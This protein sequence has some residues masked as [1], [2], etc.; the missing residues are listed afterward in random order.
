[1][2]LV[3]YFA[4][5]FT[6]ICISLAYTHQH[7]LL[8]STN[9]NIKKY[10][11]QLSQLLDHNKK[12]RYNVTTL[13]APASL[14]AKLSATG[15]DYDM[16]RQWAVV[17]RLKSTSSYEFAKVAERRNVVLEKIFNFMAVKAEAQAVEN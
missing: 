10:E 15:I 5:L 16:P 3:R 17:R 6:I 14:E 12:L 13:E 1:M 4:C 2:K 9:Y 8:I 7:F 11:T